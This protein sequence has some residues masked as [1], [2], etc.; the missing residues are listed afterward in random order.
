MRSLFMVQGEII[1]LKRTWGDRPSDPVAAAKLRLL[2]DEAKRI[3]AAEEK[4]KAK[5]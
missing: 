1:R 5:A 4:Q 2:K 3:R